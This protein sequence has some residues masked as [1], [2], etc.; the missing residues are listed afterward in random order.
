MRQIFKLIII[1]ALAIFFLLISLTHWRHSRLARR[2]YQLSASTVLSE[3]SLD[4]IVGA[5][6]QGNFQHLYQV[7]HGITLYLL[8]PP[9][10]A[11]QVT[12]HDDAWEIFD[13]SWGDFTLMQQGNE[14]ATGDLGVVFGRESI[15]D[16]EKLMIPVAKMNPNLPTG[17]YLLKISLKKLPTSWANLKITL[18]GRYEICGLERLVEQFTLALAIGAMVIFLLLLWPLVN[19]SLAVWRCWHRPVASGNGILYVLTSYPL[20]SETF[21]RLDLRFLQRHLRLLHAV[22]LYDGDTEVRPEWPQVQVLSPTSRRRRKQRPRLA[23]KL[24]TTLASLLPKW[25][26]AQCSLHTHRQ[27]RQALLEVCQ[28]KSIGHL[29]AEFADLA[30]LLAA[31]VARELGCTFSIGIHAVDIHAV[32]YPMS[33]IFGEASFITACNEAAAQAFRQKC[34][35]AAPKLN[36]I[37]HG[38]DLQH[39]PYAE[40][41]EINVESEAVLK[42]LFIGRLVPKKGVSILLEALGLLRQSGMSAIELTIIGDGPLRP[43]LEQQ[44]KQAHIS[45]LIVWAGVLEQEEVRTYLQEAS[46]LCVPSIV[47]ASGDRDGIP[48]VVTE[49]MASGVPVIG[50]QEASL[51]EVLTEE[52]GWPVTEIN[53]ENLAATIK[54]M[55]AQ[56]EERNRRRQNARR[57]MEFDFNAE[58]LAEKRSEL[59]KQATLNKRRADGAECRP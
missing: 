21:L 36:L 31:D 6:A 10:L 53:A 19:C 12:S 52:T 7:A 27:L 8:V 58:K 14:I 37:H 28:E 41:K 20:W 59:L 33:I 23:G 43:T 40:Q 32:K 54:Q 34:P 17:D 4:A 24:A 5:E 46:C 22:A 29:H 55:A 49:A 1:G 3:V 35:W 2:T 26:R 16:G 45:D 44:A 57:R 39:W 38:L 50:S 51:P 13:G 25:L 48:N 11:E 47:D 56:P 18:V 9:E 15:Q 42:L 30:A